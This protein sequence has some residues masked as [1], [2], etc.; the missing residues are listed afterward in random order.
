MSAQSTFSAAI[1]TNGN[2]R[3]GKFRSPI[4]HIKSQLSATFARS[5]EAEKISPERPLLSAFS[6]LRD[7]N[8]LDPVRTAAS[9]RTAD[10]RFRYVN[11]LLNE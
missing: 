6:P 7:V 11:D 1:Y 8:D 3:L 2:F 10:M 9:E 5:A 4:G